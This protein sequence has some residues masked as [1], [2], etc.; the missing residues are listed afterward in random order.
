M[1]MYA[2]LSNTSQH[3]LMEVHFFFS[4]WALN[5][6]RTSYSLIV[7]GGRVGEEKAR[8]W[9]GAARPGHFA[10]SWLVRLHSL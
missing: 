1:L 7:L 3:F 5:K 6:D 8:C 9:Q 2:A 4:N 10:P